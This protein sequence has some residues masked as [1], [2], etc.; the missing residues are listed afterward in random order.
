MRWTLTCTFRT[1]EHWPDPCPNAGGQGVAGSN[2]VVPTV[3]KGPLDWLLARP[4]DPSPFPG[5]GFHLMSRQLLGT[6]WGPGLKETCR[7]G[8]VFLGPGVFVPSCS[9]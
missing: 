8:T 1:G 7:S 2:P 3:Q 5:N 9:C 4:A 6:N